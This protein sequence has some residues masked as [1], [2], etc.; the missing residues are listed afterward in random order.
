[1]LIRSAR[2]RFHRPPAFNACFTSGEKQKT[3]NSSILSEESEKVLWDVPFVINAE[4][5]KVFGFWSQMN[6]C[7]DFIHSHF[8]L[9]FPSL[10]QIELSMN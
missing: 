6:L 8:A 1:M 3:K 5:M 7:S 2:F 4:I 9:D 10:H